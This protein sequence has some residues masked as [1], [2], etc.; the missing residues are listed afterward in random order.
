MNRP[1]R[2][3]K[4]TRLTRKWKGG[5]SLHSFGFMYVHPATG[6]GYSGW[7]LRRLL[8]TR[9]EQEQERLMRRRIPTM[10]IPTPWVVLASA[11]E[12]EL[13]G[14]GPLY[15]PSAAETAAKHLAA[16]VLEEAER[17]RT[18]AEQLRAKVGR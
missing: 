13:K 14:Q 3:T 7:N 17:P 1:T 15:V 4:Q 18:P 16:L 10:V 5:W 8:M 6:D 2:F 12:R 9:K 11:I